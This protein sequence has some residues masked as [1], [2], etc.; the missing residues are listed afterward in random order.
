MKFST[1]FVY[2]SALMRTGST[3]LAE[4]LTKL[5]QSFIFYEPYWGLNAFSLHTQDSEQLHKYGLNMSRYLRT[6]MPLAFMLRRLRPLGIMQDF[7]IRE[8]KR[9]LFPKLRAIGL[10]QVGVKEI[11][12]KGWQHYVRH[13]PDMKMIMLGRDPRDIYLSAYRKLQLGGTTWRGPATP[14]TI[15]SHITDEFSRQLEMRELVDCLPICYEEL[16]T[17]PRVIQ[18]ILS[19]CKSPLEDVENVGHFLKAHPNRNREYQR[20]GTTISRKSVFRWKREQDNA[21][22][23]DAREFASL[24]PEYVAFWNYDE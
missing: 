3:M 19:F 16:C 8:V 24:I 21:L 20:H 15:A 6:R 4:A 17:N 11:K 9:T 22:L 5:P 2:I 10:Q 18:R 7:M 1:P 14:Q 23:N 13:F 12:H